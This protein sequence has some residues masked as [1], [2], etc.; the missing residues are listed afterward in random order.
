MTRSEYEYVLR[1]VIG[2]LTVEQQTI[3]KSRLR[4][5]HG[6]STLVLGILILLGWFVLDLNYPGIQLVTAFK[7]LCVL[8]IAMWM[9]AISVLIRHHR[10]VQN[11]MVLEQ[12]LS[13]LE[14]KQPGSKDYFPDL[15]RA[16][17]VYGSAG[18]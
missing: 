5:V 12:A 18:W 2:E 15:R 13:S 1:S 6:S 3:V 4:R 7:I 8:G 16:R 14:P 17:A 10:I 9:I 11:L